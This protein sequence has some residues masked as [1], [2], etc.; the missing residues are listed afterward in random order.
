M[1]MEAVCQV[2]DIALHECPGVMLKTISFLKAMD[3]HIDKQPQVEI[4]TELERL[5]ISDTSF[6]TKWWR[7]VSAPYRM[8]RVILSFTLFVLSV[9]RAV[10]KH[11]NLLSIESILTDKQWSSR[12]LTSGM[13]NSP[14]KVLT[15][16]RN[17]RS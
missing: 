6:S 1:A 4:F 8:I 5:R 9:F 15:G 16:A 3:F 14:R 13:I 11:L 2:N 12:P 7:S 10:Q 17:S